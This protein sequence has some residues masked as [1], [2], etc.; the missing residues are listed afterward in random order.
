MYT[1]AHREKDT[2]TETHRHRHTDTHTDTHTYTHTVTLV[3]SPPCI[4]RSLT[5]LYM[6]V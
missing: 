1:H 5:I 4:G 3:A 2:H 6:Y